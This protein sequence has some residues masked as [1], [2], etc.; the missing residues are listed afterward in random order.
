M[1]SIANFKVGQRPSL[2]SRYSES[3]SDDDP[4]GASNHFRQCVATL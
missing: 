2:R 1:S 3:L 4:I